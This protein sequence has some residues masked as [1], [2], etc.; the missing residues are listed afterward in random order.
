MNDQ[1]ARGLTADSAVRFLVVDATEAA[2][3]ARRRHDLNPAAAR[4]VGDITLA[5]LMMSAYIKAEERLTLQLQ[6]ETPRLALICDVDAAGGVRARVRPPSLPTG[7]TGVLDGVLM[8]IKHNA[9][10]ELYRG[11]TEIRRA[12]MAHALSRHLRASSQ[13]DALLRL[14]THISAEGV[15]D[16]SVGVLVERMPPA[17][18]LPHLS[19]EAFRAHYQEIET[20][21]RDAIRAALEENTLLDAPLLSM[22]R[23]PVRWRCRCSAE[24]V[25]AMLAGL[26]PAELTEMIEQDHGAEVT[27]HFCNEVYTISEAR[28]RA[29]RA[30]YSA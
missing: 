15:V 18:D 2:D 21:D 29:L 25:E 1:L 8:V 27:C 28:L 6:A 7:W 12:D 16:A 11:V 19:P 26:G 22:E 17:P 4:L 13:V 14:Q 24:R 30:A 20:L 3:E 10:R 23:R 9:R 5:G